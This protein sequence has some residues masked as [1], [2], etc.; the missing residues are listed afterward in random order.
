MLVACGGGSSSSGGGEALSAARTYSGSETFT[1]A[2][3]G[4]LTETASGPITVTIDA[5]GNVTV[6]DEDGVDNLEASAT[7][8]NRTPTVGVES[9]AVSVAEIEILHGQ[10]GMVLVLAVT[11]GPYLD[12]VAGVHVENPVGVS[13]AQSYETT[14]IDHDVGSGVV[15]HLRC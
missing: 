6:V 11:R 2:I 5:T 14:A 3:A 8:P 9:G 10:L 1:F 12:R 13:S 4:E 7:N 15:E